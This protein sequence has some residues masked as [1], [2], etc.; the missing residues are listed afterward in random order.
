MLSYKRQF[1]NIWSRYSNS[2]V[3]NI[4]VSGKINSWL[5][6]HHFFVFEAFVKAFYTFGSS[7]K[8]SVTCTE[9][10]VIVFP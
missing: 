9:N 4:C 6:K 7:N 8:F 3:S 2:G 5:F 1:K 10:F